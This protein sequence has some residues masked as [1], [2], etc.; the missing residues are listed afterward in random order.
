MFTTATSCR[1]AGIIAAEGRPHYQEKS[2]DET[3]RLTF[4]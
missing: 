1:V 2:R 3:K 4:A